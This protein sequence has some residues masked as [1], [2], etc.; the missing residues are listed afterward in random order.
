MHDSYDIADLCRELE[1][2]RK[3]V[4]VRTGV[5]TLFLGGAYILIGCFVWE[6]MAAPWPPERPAIAYL[7]VLAAW[8]F[9][10]A[11]GFDKINLRLLTRWPR[12]PVCR[13][14][15]VFFQPVSRRCPECHNVIV[16][17]RRKLLPGYTLPPEAMR[18]RNP[19]QPG[20]SIGLE[21][22]QLLLM[23]IVCIPALVVGFFLFPEDGGMDVESPR[24]AACFVMALG[25]FVILYRFIGVVG[26]EKLLELAAW[27]DR[28]CDRLNRKL[29]KNYR[30]MIPDPAHHCPHCHREP[31]HRLAAVTGNC[32]A[33]GAPLLETAPEPDTPEMMDWRNL[34]RYG[35][36]QR[37]GLS[38]MLGVLLSF[39]ILQIIF[40][41]DRRYWAA[42][43]ILFPGILLFWWTVVLWS[44]RRK[45]Q[46]NFRCPGCRYQNGPSNNVSAWRFLLQTG[47]CC[48][49]RRKLVRDGESGKG[50]D[51]A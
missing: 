15:L 12:C 25:V 31:D 13:K 47:H 50:D 22:G 51:R 29:N 3:A 39:L 5:F 10:L 45:W 23:V 38:F 2:K 40:Q 24:L 35:K 28:K 16:Y 48:R 6:Q 46:L 9:L 44:L 34:H 30:S 26:V 18:I 19:N 8:P 11:A 1:A 21:V 36:I 27:L 32:S 41:N 42:G 49:C 37:I 20:I 43:G 33:C 14:K 17:D 4:A 7:V